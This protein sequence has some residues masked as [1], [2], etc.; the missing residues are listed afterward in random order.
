MG[1]VGSRINELKLSLPDAPKPVAAYI[2]AKQT[3]NLVFTAGQI[4]MVNGE[5][6]SKGLLGQD[7]EVDA[8]N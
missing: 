1:K 5:L 3:G 7:V 2:P 8:A 4:P 6:I